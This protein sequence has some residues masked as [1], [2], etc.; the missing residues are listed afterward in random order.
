MKRQIS[1][2]LTAIQFLTRL[3][4]PAQAQFELSWLAQSLRYFPLV[5][6]GIGA[7]GVGVEWLASR[8]FAPTVAVALMLSA[9]LLLTGALHE[10][11]WADVCDGFGG[12]ATRERVL[13]IMRDSRV[14]AYGAIGV[15]M[16]LLLKWA[17]LTALPTQVLPFTWVAA[18][19]SSRWYA[20][21]LVW[22]L[23]YARADEDSKS[24][25]FADG[26]STSEWLLSALLGCLALVPVALLSDRSVLLPL[27]G[28]FL[29]ALIIAAI[30]AVIAGLYFKRRIGG[31]TGD[32][33]G[34]TQQLTELG[35]LLTVL[36]SMRY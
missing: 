6:A 7:V 3:P 16:L 27:T 4:I 18:Q 34:A 20:I 36:G 26:L 32:C 31:Y 5:G 15:G 17:G 12:G 9:V 8:W 35:F 13:A 11:G 19:M 30:V 29:V 28:A 23:S 22:R 21:G 33:L 10:D 2:L 24:K 14:G 25:P 1:L